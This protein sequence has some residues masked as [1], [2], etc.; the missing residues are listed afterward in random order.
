MLQELSRKGVRVIAVNRRSDP[1]L[2]KECPAKY[3]QADICDP[4]AVRNL[5]ET[6]DREG[7]RPELMVLNAGINRADNV[8]RFDYGT[9]HEVMRINLDGVLTFVSAAHALGWKGCTFAAMSSTS[10]IIPNPGHVAYALSKKA[11]K[12]AFSLLAKNDPENTYKTVVLGPVYTNI[13]AGY[14]PLQGV[15]KKI[16]DALAVSSE[17]AASKCLRFFGGS[18]SVFPYP[19]RAIAFYYSV[20]V[21]LCIFP[22]LYKG[23]RRAA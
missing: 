9:F 12:E 21:L 4:L 23:T 15:Q 11:L 7:I 19:F 13:S 5:L 22:G 14:A 3:V 20:R 18:R 2:E 16:F 8:E 1:Q 6:L 17:E 10:N